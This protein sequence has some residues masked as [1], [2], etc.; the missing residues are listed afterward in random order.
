LLPISIPRCFE[1]ASELKDNSYK[2]GM[3]LARLQSY[4]AM[5]NCEIMKIPLSCAAMMNCEIMKIPFRYFEVSKLS[6]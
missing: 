5:L 2:I 6:K 3:E 1:V 4:A